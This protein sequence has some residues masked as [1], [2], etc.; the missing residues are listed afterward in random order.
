MSYLADDLICL[1]R[2]RETRKFLTDAV[3]LDVK[4]QFL[5]KVDTAVRLDVKAP[6]GALCPRTLGSGPEKRADA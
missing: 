1:W 6:L 5:G 2:W 4:P 3:R